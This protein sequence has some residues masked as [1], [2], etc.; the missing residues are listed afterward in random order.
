MMK[1]ADSAGQ[2]CSIIIPTIN[3]NINYAVILTDSDV[4]CLCTPHT[5]KKDHMNTCHE[6]NCLC[7]TLQNHI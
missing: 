4:K 5:L 2:E 6:V 3:F 1:H 7:A